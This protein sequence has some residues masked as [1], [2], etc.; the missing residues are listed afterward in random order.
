L[1]VVVVVVV[2]TI[3]SLTSSEVVRLTLLLRIWKVLVSILG[4]QADCRP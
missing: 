4:P 3:I 1:V 2:V